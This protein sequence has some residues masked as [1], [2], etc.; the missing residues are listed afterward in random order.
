MS[1]NPGEGR[2]CGVSA[3]STVVPRSPNKLGDLTPY[4]TYGVKIL[5]K[6]TVV[7]AQIKLQDM[8]RHDKALISF[9]N[10]DGQQNFK[11][12]LLNLLETMI[13]VAFNLRISHAI[14]Q[15][16]LY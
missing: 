9:K 15:P 10:A 13:C 7:S 11:I 16:L 12:L 2:N 6:G 5:K 3:K 1:P 4:L 8:I 14:V